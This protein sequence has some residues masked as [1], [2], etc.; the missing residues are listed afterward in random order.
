VVFTDPEVAWTGLT[1]AEAKA[2]G[3]AV[4]VKKMQWVASGRAVALG[5]T[6]G[7]TKI[8]FDP[9]SRRV[10]GVGITGPHAGEMIAEGVLAIE[11]GAVA[12]DLALTIHPHPTVSELVGDVA[13]LMM[14]PG[15]TPAH[16]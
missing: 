4:E 9:E 2:K 12:D 10:L 1:E 6:D 11:M 3:I 8:L 16:G 7:I 13:D 15:G 5:R 14:S